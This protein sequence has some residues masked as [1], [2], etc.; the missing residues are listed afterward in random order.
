LL[1]LLN[2]SGATKSKRHGS[3]TE[4]VF[5]KAKLSRLAKMYELSI[6]VKVTDQVGEIKENGCEEEDVYLL[7]LDGYV[8]EE[9][10]SEENEESTSISFGDLKAQNEQLHGLISGILTSNTT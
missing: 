1:P 8:F 3:G 4:L 7:G 5:D 2:N 10:Q 6:D 9:D